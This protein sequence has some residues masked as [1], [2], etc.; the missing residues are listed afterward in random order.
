MP[1]IAPKRLQRVLILAVALGAI[2]IAVVA[3]ANSPLLAWRDPV[4]IGAGFAGIIALALLLIQPLLAGGWLP[5]MQARR[6]RQVHKW[7]GVTLLLAVVLHVAGLWI[8]SP[9]DVVDALLFVSPTPFSVWGVI[10]MWAVF[11]SACLAIFRRRLRFRTWRLAHTTL[12][13][14]IVI[15]SCVHALRIEGTMETVSKVLL[16]VLVLGATF[17][18]IADLRGW[19]AK[20]AVRSTPH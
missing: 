18:V 12:A 2:C 1:V 11:A 3:A 10:A 9:P 16:C 4:Y 20:S 14:V 17:A 6:G 5:A 8:T 15:G 13:A 7:V 19:F